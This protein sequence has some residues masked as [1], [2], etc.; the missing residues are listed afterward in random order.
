[1]TLVDLG[2]AILP[3]VMTFS[4]RGEDDFQR[5]FGNSALSRG[6]VFGLVH[7]YFAAFTAPSKGSLV[8]QFVGVSTSEAAH[9]WTW[10]RRTVGH[11][12][13]VLVMICTVVA[14]VSLAIHVQ[15]EL[16][17]AIGSVPTRGKAKNATS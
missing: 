17:E 14:A 6:S 2:I 16:D 8:T 10:S 3:Y 9:A 4:G 12:A 11:V 15:R 7:A 1:M 5:F 13:C